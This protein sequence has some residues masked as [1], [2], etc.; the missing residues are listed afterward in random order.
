MAKKKRIL[1]KKKVLLVLLVFL[2]VFSFGYLF[3]RLWEGA[4]KRFMFAEGD[5]V[6][7]ELITSSCLCDGVQ[8]TNGYCCYYSVY[9]SS[10]IVYQTDKCGYT[11]VSPHW[12]HILT[13]KEEYRWSNNYPGYDPAE[14]GWGAKHY[15]AL[16]T[17]Y[18]DEVK[19]YN[20]FAEIYR[21]RLDLSIINDMPGS[22]Y[23][24][25]Y[26]DMILF[27]Q[28]NGYNLEDI[29]LHFSEDTTVFL[30][31]RTK[32]DVQVVIPGCP[33]TKTEACRV[34]TSVWDNARWAINPDSVLAKN[35]YAYEWNLM[36]SE[37]TPGGNV[38]DGLFLDEHP[39]FPSGSTS[40]ISGGGLLEYG[41][42]TWGNSGFGNLYYPSVDSF[43]LAQNNGMSP[44]KKLIPNHAEYCTRSEA[45]SQSFSADGAWFEF[46]LD[47][48]RQRIGVVEMWDK[49]RQLMD[50]GKIVV[51]STRQKG[52]GNPDGMNYYPAG[53]TS[54]SYASPGARAQIMELAM[55]YL[56]KD[57]ENKL[58]Y[59]DIL[60]AWTV[61]Y[62]QS[63]TYAQEVDIGIAVGDYYIFQTG[64]DP[65]GNGYTIYA[66]DFEK[67]I[68]LV[69]PKGNWNQDIFGDS[70]AVN[71]N[72][73]GNYYIVYADG[74]ISVNPVA[75]IN[76]RNSEGSIL[77]LE[78]PTPFTCSEQGGNYCLPSDECNGVWTP[79]SDTGYCC[80]GV[81][82][83]P[84][85]T[86]NIQFVEP[87]PNNGAVVSENSAKINFSVT[88]SSLDEFKFNLDGTYYS[89]YDDNLS[90]MMNF[91]NVAALGEDENT[92]KD[93]STYNRAIVLSGTSSSTNGVRGG[94]R[95]FGNS[96]FLSVPSLDGINF[97]QS[98][99]TISFW[100]YGN[101]SN[102]GD[103]NF[104]LDRYDSNRNYIM[105]R[106]AD[107]GNA[108]QIAFTN[109]SIHNWIMEKKIYNV[110]SDYKWTHVALT[111][112]TTSRFAHI[113]V[114]GK[115]MRIGYWSNPGWS[116][117]QQIV[118]IGV[119]FQDL[120]DEFR[121][122]NYSM[123]KD[124]VKE[125]YSSYLLKQD[126]DK[127]NFFINQSLEN[128]VHTYLGYAKD[129][130]GSEDQTETRTINVV[131]PEPELTNVDVNL[132]FNL[133]E[134]TI[135]FAYGIQEEGAVDEMMRPEFPFIAEHHGDVAT[136]DRIWMR[137]SYVSSGYQDN[138]P[139]QD[140]CVTY[141]YTKISAIVESV[142][143]KGLTP[144]ISF[145]NFPRCM[146]PTG[147][148]I[149][150]VNPVPPISPWDYSDF[151]EY[152]SNVVEHFY[153]ACND[154]EITNCGN[155][156]NWRWEIFNEP[157]ENYWLNPNNYPYSELYTL[158][159]NA[160]KEK[161]PV[162]NVGSAGSL[163]D[164]T[165]PLVL[166][167]NH[168][169]PDVY[170]DFVSVHQ[171]DNAESADDELPGY[172]GLTFE[173]FLSETK[174]NYYD[175]MNSVDNVLKNY[176]TNPKL[177]NSEYGMSGSISP[178]VVKFLTMPEAGTW[179]A[180]A[181]YWAVQTDMVGEF[182]YQG[183][184]PI[185][186]A[187]QGMWNINNDIKPV[188]Y[189]KK[190]WVNRF[191]NGEIIYLGSSSNS[192]VEIMSTDENLVVIN[193]LDSPVNLN[194]NFENKNIDSLTSQNGD[195]ILSDSNS[196]DIELNNF[197]VMFYSL[198]ELI[199][200]PEG[201]GG[202][203]SGG[204]GGGGGGGG[205]NDDEEIRNEVIDAS[206][207]LLLRNDL[208]LKQ[209][210]EENLGRSLSEE[211]IGNM[212]SIIPNAMGG[213]IPLKRE[214]KSSNGKTEL[215]ARF[216]YTGNKK[217]VNL[218]V[219]EVHPKYLEFNESIEISALGGIDE[220][221]NPD[222]SYLFFYPEI[223]P[224]Q[225][226]ELVYNFDRA[227]MRFSSIGNLLTNVYATNLEDVVCD[228]DGNC[229]VG[230]GEN[231]F[232]CRS[233]CPS[234]CVPDEKRCMNEN[235]EVCNTLGESWEFEKECKFGCDKE[236]LL[237]KES[238]EASKN[239]WTKI[240]SFIKSYFIYAL[241]L[242]LLIAI[243]FIG[244]FIYKKIRKRKTSFQTGVFLDKR[245]RK[246]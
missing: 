19:L 107:G 63:W 5:C 143:N 76:L 167:F 211:E 54:G 233:D 44:E 150:T 192:G 153:N 43:L 149:T 231:S 239:L 120:I 154:G 36:T 160:I 235:L 69:R 65:A 145:G 135:N 161:V 190:E 147:S 217:A 48:N 152:A 214:L 218:F 31:F 83:S 26:N 101:F 81:C 162:A 193:K 140:N 196:F 114:N 207:N 4:E 210:I 103:S 166:F 221:V 224:G 21:Y 62:V 227:T 184:D 23:E 102:N 46:M 141:N 200:P 173:E 125:L 40:I 42:I 151:A 142:L 88:S 67:A 201:G 32:P 91:D 199:S 137:H 41:G 194:L 205:S 64:T 243:T 198:S 220:V 74:S 104:I 27:A 219:Y 228:N 57:R 56:G 226:V 15:D 8:R 170:P 86:L 30:D 136:Y 1:F 105:I 85:Q 121:I 178:R 229:E 90:L 240:K 132:D 51:Y 50:S 2:L 72:L 236:T 174:G 157:G 185:E 34:Q 225:I 181:L 29:F 96:E 93:L 179:H 66:R 124:E 133:P 159:Y 87:T 22:I 241:I 35:F 49:A 182:W 47:P 206:S 187:S 77:L 155:F 222:P 45:M 176:Y 58:A 129:V 177:Y 209:S 106:T 186:Y 28:Q 126:L 242:V 99:G 92:I 59:F 55:Y 71:V 80:L 95:F 110:L 61:P 128:G 7:R 98:E 188:F 79:A 6:N 165:A 197:G 175:F 116:P 13:F 158:T 215:S 119:N 204:G 113:Y 115:L 11:E 234:L 89:F 24:E 108:L 180:S 39:F 33:M 168:I 146:L 37:L 14:I 94:S 3:Y 202:G 84:Q 20:P 223:Y 68:V 208:L 148:D 189:T 100:V 78:T 112:N 75:T 156:E 212:V 130:G 97:P 111:Y 109:G 171:Y 131:L 164:G 144:Y 246:I 117:N 12:E 25:I 16:I 138:I 216:I 169:T 52:A 123:E 232:G 70:T 127:W 60:G 18:N 203:S 172:M 230:L 238:S 139:L 213:M 17:G 244:Y 38:F 134:K 163:G 195:I 9:P 245:Y 10:N 122:Y 237:C 82:G 191:P 53:Y 73:G 118:E 183:T